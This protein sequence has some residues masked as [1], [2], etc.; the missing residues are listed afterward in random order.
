M[1]KHSS[2]HWV[3]K[4]ERTESLPR[5]ESELMEGFP[6]P[7]V[8]NTHLVV[9]LQRRFLDPIPKFWDSG[10]RE[11]LKQMC[12]DSLGVGRSVSWFGVI[13]ALNSG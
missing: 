13:C 3:T 5:T 8:H 7:G 9:L 10:S 12:S 4:I 6:N 11:G 2:G 1:I